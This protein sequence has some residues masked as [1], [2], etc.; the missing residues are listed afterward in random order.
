MQALSAGN[1]IETAANYAGVSPQTVHEWIS[2]GRA[3]SARKVEEPVP[4][5]TC[6]A[7]VGH[8]CT[9]NTG[10]DALHSHAP[11]VHR[12]EA[13]TDEVYDE[14]ANAVDNARASAEIRMLSVVQREAMDGTWQAAA[15]YLERSSPQKWGRRITEVSGRGGGP[16]EIAEMSGEQKRLRLE[17]V[18]DEIERRLS[19]E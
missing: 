3:A 12:P 6:S 2:R 13:D 4:C 18:R 7:A 5:P 11:R 19:T 14:F 15:W 17:M 8:P 1:Y 10:E 9:T 16:I